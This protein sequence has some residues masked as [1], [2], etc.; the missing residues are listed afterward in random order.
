MVD[1]MLLP[2]FGKAISVNIKGL[3]VNNKMKWKM[4]GLSVVSALTYRM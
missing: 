2:I 4:F 1:K 3:V